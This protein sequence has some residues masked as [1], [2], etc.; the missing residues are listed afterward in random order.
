MVYCLTGVG[1]P[2]RPSFVASRATP[3]RMA[4]HANQCL[5]YSG[6]PDNGHSC[7]QPWLGTFAP[8]TVLLQ[9][10]VYRLV[11]LPNAGSDRHLRGRLQ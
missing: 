7:K 6:K 3:A 1:Y 11:V 2:R 4:R 8:V 10:K 5:S 9:A